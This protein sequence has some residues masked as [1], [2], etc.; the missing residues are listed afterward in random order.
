[1]PAACSSMPDALDP[2]ISSLSAGTVMRPR[3]DAELCVTSTLAP[4]GRDTSPPVGTAPLG[5]V[6]GECQ[7]SRPGCS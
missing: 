1:M 6:V 2:M 3:M 5:H 7:L 4:A